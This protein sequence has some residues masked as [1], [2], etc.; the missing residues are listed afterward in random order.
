MLCIQTNYQNKIHL[1]ISAAIIDS[2]TETAGGQQTLA[3]HHYTHYIDNAETC[4]VE[5]KVTWSA[6]SGAAT[7]CSSGEAQLC[8]Q[9]LGH[10]L[11]PW[12]AEVAH[13]T[14]KFLPDGNHR[15]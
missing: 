4:L 5:L 8:K 2:N 14:G 3:T 12:E 9:K 10:P 13:N 7:K 15:H 1:C 11:Q 6:A